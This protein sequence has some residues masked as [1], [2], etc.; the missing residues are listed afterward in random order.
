MAYGERK[1]NLLM[2]KT[3]KIKR[4]AVIVFVI[5][6]VL[7][8]LQTAQRVSPLILRS[9]FFTYSLRS[10]LWMFLSLA[11]NIG[12]FIL[13]FLLLRTIIKNDSPFMKKTVAL[14]KII[15]LLFIFVDVEGA[16]GTIYRNF[17]LRNTPAPEPVYTICEYTGVTVYIIAPEDITVIWHGGFAVIAGLII[18]LIALVLKHGISLQ[19]QVDETL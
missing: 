19:T 2:S 17:Q 15:A 10:P 6:S 18:Y 4:T 5:F 13:C 8:F 12:I 14:L 9:D 1:E 3:E 7:F 11:L 16:I